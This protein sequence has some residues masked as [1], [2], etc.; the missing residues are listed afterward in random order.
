MCEPVTQALNNSGVAVSTQWVKVRS[1]TETLPAPP[2]EV[3]WRVPTWLT[4]HDHERT[5][6]SSLWSL[7]TDSP[8]MLVSFRYMS[9]AIAISLLGSCE[10]R[11]DLTLFRRSR[12]FGGS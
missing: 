2:P 1:P 8:L 9:T 5:S 11:S 12:F 6:I 3:W 4:P 7:A 10:V